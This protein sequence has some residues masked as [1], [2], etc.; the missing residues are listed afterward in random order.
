MTSIYW[1]RAPSMSG[2][3]KPAYKTG[4]EKYNYFVE[5]HAHEALY[6]IFRAKRDSSDLKPLHQAKTVSAAKAWVEDQA[7]VKKFLKDQTA[8][9]AGWAAEREAEEISAKKERLQLAVKEPVLVLP[10]FKFGHN[11]PD[12][13]HNA[14]VKAEHFDGTL[15][16]RVRQDR[17]GKTWFVSAT[18]SGLAGDN[19]RRSNTL[20]TNVK[21]KGE[22]WIRA[23]EAGRVRVDE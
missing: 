5:P 7:D 16:Y 18:G 15:R 3:P 13:A 4:T 1:Q 22:Y 17:V 21:S 9:Y 20:R 2:S 6:V 10:P 11:Q 14:K 19:S 23:V 12:P 8:M